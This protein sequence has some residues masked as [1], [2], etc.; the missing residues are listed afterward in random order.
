MK[1]FFSI[2]IIF[3]VLSVMG[4]LGYGA[5]DYIEQKQSLKFTPII[6]PDSAVDTNQAS[7]TPDNII[8]TVDVKNWKIYDNQELGYSI[9]YPGDLIVNYDTLSLILAFPKDKYFNWPLLD[10][11]KLTLV[12]TSTCSLVTASSSEITVNDIK[13]KVSRS[14]DAAMGTVYKKDSYEIYG[15]NACYIITMD[16]KGT[17]GSGFYVDDPSLIKKYDN[18]HKLDLDKVMSVVYGILGSFEIK[19]IDS[20]TVES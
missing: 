20:G 7:S 5:Y 10:D 12:S 13:Y 4:V 15:N 11:V 2:I 14:N 19:N 3:I 16:S 1:K 9:K 18:Q 17:N 8:S 6:S